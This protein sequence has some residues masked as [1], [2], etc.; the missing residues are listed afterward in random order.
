[1]M[2]MTKRCESTR[3]MSDELLER[4]QGSEKKGGPAADDDDE[5]KGPEWVEFKDKSGQT[6]WVRRHLRFVV[7]GLS[8]M[9]PLTQKVSKVNPATL[10]R[11]AF[12]LLAQYSHDTVMRQALSRLT[13]TKRARTKTRTAPLR[14]VSLQCKLC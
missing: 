14:L 5:D 9:N 2:T 7:H 10:P 13:S 3:Q 8:Q 6:I 1:M 11:G 12:A 4:V